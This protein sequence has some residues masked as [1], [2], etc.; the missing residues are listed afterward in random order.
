MIVSAIIVLGLLGFIFAALLALAAD[1]FRIEVD[2]RLTAISAALPGTNCGACGSAGCQQFA[3]RLLK[4][5][6]RIDGCVAG[7]VTV[8]E[9]LAKVLGVDLAVC[10]E[11]RIAAVHCG[12]SESQRRRK[13]NYAGV[14]TCRAADLIDNGGLMC[15]YGCLGYGDC[16]PV[17]PFDAITMRDG[18]PAVDP[19]K[20]TA[21]NKCVL[22]CPRQIIALVPCGAPAL[23][24]CSS[25]DGPAATRKNCPVG[26]IA[27]K[28][29]EQ[30]VPSVFAVVDNLAV[31]DYAKKD[32]NCDQAKTKCP[33]K[34]II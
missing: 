27:C 18:L 21:C 10:A 2:P 26:C 32:V 3:E 5:E 28:I 24:A 13:A 15:S 7:G 11:R 22:E 8:A 25:H 6:V 14:K 30:A 1:Y 19:V 17:C 23:I 9:R 16:C 34:C 33:T 31:I 4:G 12:A 20:C 29:C